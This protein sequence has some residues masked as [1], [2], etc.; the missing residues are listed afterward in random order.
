MKILYAAGNRI[1][2][3]FQLKRFLQSI[4]HKN[5]DIR[6]AAYKKSSGDLNIDYTLDS[7]LNIT[8]PREITFNGNYLYLS[9][10][11]QRFSPDLIIS[12]FDIY[13]SNIALDLNLRLWQ[14]S[15]NNLYY[16]LS[17]EMRY[18]L[19]IHKNYFFLLDATNKKND[20]VNNIL[21]NSSRKFVLSHMGDTDGDSII[22][23]GYEWVRPNFILG[24]GSNKIDYLV[25]LLQSNKFIF[26]KLKNKKSLAFYPNV[27]TNALAFIY[28][29]FED[30]SYKKC[31]ENCKF[32]ISDGSGIF[33]ADAFYNQKYAI[34]YPRYDDIET[35]V[36]TTI[37]QYFNLGTTGDTEQ[38]IPPIDIKLNN[39]IKFISEYIEEV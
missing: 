25:T 12:D 13:I 39:K 16:A 31:L 21:N 8:N 2:S 26:D 27:E 1:G 34:S 7:L 9:K 32:F 38:I 17:Y 20:Y 10:E 36:G 22:T 29:I 23:N 19:K 28:N 5:Y 3:F 14:F 6:I 18:K 4:Q 35:I 24:D 30:F 37:N 11:I 15:P 33:L